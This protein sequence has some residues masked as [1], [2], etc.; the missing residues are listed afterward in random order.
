[1]VRFA[2]WMQSLQLTFQ[3]LI[4]LLHVDCKVCITQIITDQ[5]LSQHPFYQLAQI[6]DIRG[7]LG[8]TTTDTDAIYRKL[9]EMGVSMQF[10]SS[11][12]FDEKMMDD[13]FVLEL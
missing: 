4:D 9:D 7:L 5:Q 3:F 1:M 8:E 10:H 11:K 13:T 2:L 6:N 12:E